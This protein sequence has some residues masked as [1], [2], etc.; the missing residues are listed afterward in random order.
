MLS[1]PGLRCGQELTETIIRRMAAHDSGLAM[2]DTDSESMNK[3]ISRISGG[4]LILVVLGILA[5]WKLDDVRSV[6]SGLS[7]VDEMGITTA[8]ALAAFA[9]GAGFVVIHFGVHESIDNL[10]FGARKEVDTHICGT[11][12]KEAGATLGR[13]VTATDGD[14]MKLFYSFTNQLDEKWPTLRSRAFEVWGQ[15]YISMNIVAISLVAI[16]IEIMLVG[17]DS[18]D[19]PLSSLVILVL[20][21]FGLLVGYHSQRRIRPKF[22]DSIADSQLIMMTKDQRQEFDSR[23]RARFGG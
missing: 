14:L 10:L 7:R 18:P 20:L 12:R 6:V 4:Y 9:S 19:L 1:C 2:T 13:E 3:H 15:Y 8:A 11:I 17:V 21:S 22:I 5:S 23:V 16:A